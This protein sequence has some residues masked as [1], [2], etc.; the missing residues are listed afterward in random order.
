MFQDGH[1]GAQPPPLP[2]MKVS[3]NSSSGLGSGHLGVASRVG[4]LGTVEDV[5][6]RCRAMPSSLPPG[7][8]ERRG[9]PMALP[10]SSC[11]R[12]RSGGA[13]PGDGSSPP[14][15]T[16]FSPVSRCLWDR[17]LS[18]VNVRTLTPTPHNPR[19][20]AGLGDSLLDILG[21]FIS[22]KDTRLTMASHWHFSTSPSWYI[23]SRIL[24]SHV[25]PSAQGKRC[26]GWRHPVPPAPFPRATHPIWGWWQ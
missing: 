20:A 16:G 23:S 15:G 6:G 18:S 2:A 26:K 14:A 5:V 8:G 10:C 24:L 11:P 7:W 12:R 25:V 21:A 17:G 9:A 1:P 22:R 4:D 13:G 3:R 19:G